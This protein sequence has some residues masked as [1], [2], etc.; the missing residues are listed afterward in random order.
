MKRHAAPHIRLTTYKLGDYKVIS[1]IAD[2]TFGRCFFVED[3][4]GRPF[5][6]KVVKQ[7]KRYIE[8]AKEEVEI[9]RRFNRKDK[10]SDYAPRWIESFY[11]HGYYVIITTMHG[12]SL[13][14]LLQN[15]QD[16]KSRIMLGIPLFLIRK[17][18][19][20]LVAA[21]GFMHSIEMTHT[22]LKVF[23]ILP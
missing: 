11:F 20:S 17:I 13:Y 19:R 8:S 4:Q 14:Q 22:D 23:S 7:V 1:H 10:S 3:K 18:A 21:V 12:Y 15:N 9:I 16:G 2:G 5:A 6:A